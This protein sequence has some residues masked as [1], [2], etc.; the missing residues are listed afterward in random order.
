MKKIAV[1]IAIT[2]MVLLS[3]CTNLH[4]T[5]RNQQEEAR[6]IVIDDSLSYRIYVDRITNVMYLRTKTGSG[7]ALCVMADASGKP[8][9]WEGKS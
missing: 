4:D 2:A 8:L 5:E 1:F 6:L 3:G 9:L 7:E